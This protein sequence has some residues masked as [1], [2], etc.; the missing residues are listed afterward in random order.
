MRDEGQLE[1][2]G[3]L[4]NGASNGTMGLRPDMTA[5]LSS[6]DSEEEEEEDVV[7]EDVRGGVTAGDAAKKDDFGC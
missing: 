5:S 6:G 1:S 2:S 4:D 3:I 7:V